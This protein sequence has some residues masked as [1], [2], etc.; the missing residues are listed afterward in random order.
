MQTKAA[1]LWSLGSPWSVEEIELDPPGP[2]EV[3]VSL[4]AV[5][6]CHTD[7]HSVTGDLPAPLPMIGGHEGAGIV[8]EVGPGVT[9]LATGDHVAM[10]FIPSCGRCACCVAG[11]QNLCDL[12]MHLGAG[13]ALADGGF[14]AHARG[15]DV[16]SG[17]M[18]G[19]FA[20]H[21]VVNEASLVKIDP[22]VPLDLACLVSC[23]VAT[24]WGSAVHAANVRV[25]DTVVVVG[26]GGLGMNAVQGA[27]AAGAVQIVAVDP[28]DWKR[29]QAKSFGATHAADSVGSALE[30]VA[31]ITG[32]TMA[33]AAIL[34]TGVATGDLLGPT[35]NLVGKGGTVVVT[36]VAPVTQ[37][38]VDLNL[39]ELTFWEKTVKGALYGSGNPRSD[40][41]NLLSLYTRGEL[42]LDELITA[43][44]S[45]DRINEGYEDMRAGRNIRGVVV[46]DPSI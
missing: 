44:Y 25:G 2:G 13:R 33:Q 34:T 30:L 6:L 27:R 12:G 45:L 10:S 4:A 43:R 16:A 20:E 28:I 26:V 15:V 3:L 23:G 1:V 5:G 8:A 29:E 9:S 7:E 18:L 24:G 38:S 19:A 32:G 36:A 21:A 22:D 11:R 39:V 17:N 31:E 42:L 37:T 40:I 41:P 35:V 46:M 14:R